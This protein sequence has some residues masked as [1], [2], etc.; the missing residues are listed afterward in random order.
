MQATILSF[1]FLFINNEVNNDF[2]AGDL[3]TSLPTILNDHDKGEAYDKIH[4]LITDIYNDLTNG[5]SS[6]CIENS[7][8]L[9]KTKKEIKL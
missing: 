2:G 4:K 3:V 6:I 9:F 5:T 7:N 1:L 8:L